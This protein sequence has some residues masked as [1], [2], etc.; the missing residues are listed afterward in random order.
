M[1]LD[2]SSIW[3]VCVK[4][5]LAAWT[6]AVMSQPQSMVTSAPDSSIGLPWYCSGSRC[7]IA[8]SGRRRARRRDASA[9]RVIGT[10]KM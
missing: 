1:P 5:P 10:V 8:P 4:R 3:N 7:S 6:Y 2:R 9:Y